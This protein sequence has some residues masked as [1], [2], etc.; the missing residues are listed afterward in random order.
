MADY[1]RS[2]E[3]FN[4]ELSSL[5]A[6]HNQNEGLRDTFIGLGHTALFA[7][8]ISFV[9]DLFP[10]GKAELVWL[11]IMAW[12]SSCIG[13]IAFTLSFSESRKAI[14]ARRAALNEKEAPRASKLEA[15][16]AVSL[17]SFPVSLIAILIFASVNLV[18]S[19]DKEEIRHQ[20][21]VTGLGD[22]RR[23]TPFASP[24]LQPS[25]KSGYR[26]GTSPEGTGACPSSATQPN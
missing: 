15:L 21:N 2:R 6:A 9:A 12:V 20:T 11:I 4:A 24:G 13:L 7:A 1:N 3:E 8:S 10:V 23:D 25:S 26:S 5:D 22:V 16:N 14:D 18:K 17:W 19:H